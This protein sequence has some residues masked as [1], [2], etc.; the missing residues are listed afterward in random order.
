MLRFW[1][2]GASLGP[3]RPLLRML[4]LSCGR[5]VTVTRLDVAQEFAVQIRTVTSI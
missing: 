2:L 1:P 3:Q 4:Y 5:G